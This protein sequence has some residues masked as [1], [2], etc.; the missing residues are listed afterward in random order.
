MPLNYLEKITEDKNTKEMAEKLIKQISTKESSVRTTF[1]LTK[2]GE[3]ALAWI[4][5]HS[6]KNIRSI[7]DNFCVPLLTLSSNNME[8]PFEN[9]IIEFAKKVPN[10]SDGKIR[11]S[12][13]LSKKSLNILNNIAKKY[14]VSRDA[15]LDLSFYLVMAFLEDSLKTRL[16][17][18]KKALSM[19]KE[20][21]GDAEDV[22]KKLKEFLDEND[23]VLCR[24]GYV[25]VH[26]MNISIAIEKEQEDGT[27]IQPDE[28]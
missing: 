8:T 14:Q 12:I 10:S 24:L 7:I 16:D 18:H 4:I 6:K 19:I 2:D 23:P 20:L 15:L 26:L 13:V 25:I 11:R 9:T 17:N 22:E 21:W 3:A 28:T 5:E 27:P 1:A